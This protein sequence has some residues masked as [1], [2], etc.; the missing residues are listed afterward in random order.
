MLG[1]YLI[2]TVEVNIRGP[3]LSLSQPLSEKLQ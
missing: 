2:R 1:I 3:S